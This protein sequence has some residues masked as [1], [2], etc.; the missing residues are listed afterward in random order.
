MSWGQL[1]NLGSDPDV[2]FHILLELTL[3]LGAC[4]HILFLARIHLGMQ[5]QIRFDFGSDPFGHADAILF[6]NAQLMPMSLEDVLPISF[7]I[8]P[9]HFAEQRTAG[10]ALSAVVAAAKTD[11][12][13]SAAKTASASAVTH[14][15]SLPWTTLGRAQGC[16]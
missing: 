9:D 4:A 10:L 8:F 12:V 3:F 16:C 5:M 13:V 11:S 2:I 7:C 15:S 14:D 1:A 6:V